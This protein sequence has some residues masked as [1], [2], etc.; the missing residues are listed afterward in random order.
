MKIGIDISML[1][2]QGSGVARYTYNFVK[3]L[4]T[5][6]KGN[7]YKLF[8]SSLRKPKDFY[9]LNDLKKAG[10]KIYSYSFPPRLIRFW[11][12]RY[13]MFPIEWFMGK[14]DIFH[15]SDYLRPPFS[16]K[17]KGITTIHD[18]TWKKFPEFHTNDVVAA[19]ERKLEKT[20][21]YKDLI[22][23]DSFQTRDDL[24]FY[25]PE[26]DRKKILVN[27]PG[28]DYRFGVIHNEKRMR[29]VLSK[30]GLS[31]PKRYLLYVG[32]IEP[33]KNLDTSIKVFS[34]LIKKKTYSDFEFLVVGRAGWKN[35]N[36]FQLVKDLG[37]QER[38]KFVGFVE[39]EDL[40]YFYN[41]AKVCIY[42][43]LYE[44]FG[45]PPLEAAKCSIPS[46][47]YSNSSLKEIMPPDYPFAQKGEELTTLIQLIE[48]KVIINQKHFEKFNWIMYSK[49]FLKLIQAH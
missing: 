39:D 16:K 36:I 15:S 42:L 18:L 48:D 29:E 40:P 5:T 8:Y 4:L 43:S 7:E 24:L 45:L 32:A 44:G 14:V 17:T 1:V 31:Y 22:M 41:T 47:V 12:N 19:H 49:K 46:L 37:L 11:W 25:Y 38:V 20:V 33:R 23:V 21:R 35:E 3:S 6:D 13:H 10:G 9:S 34:Q 2:Y 27:Y 30:Y 26:I 28:I